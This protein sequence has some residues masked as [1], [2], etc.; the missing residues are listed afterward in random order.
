MVIAI[1]LSCQ[2]ILCCLVFCILYQADT[3]KKENGA[4]DCSNNNCL[5][6]PGA[7][8]AVNKSNTCINKAHYSEYRQKDSKYAFF[9]CVYFFW[10]QRTTKPA[11]AV[12]KL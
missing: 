9:H 10:Q 5:Y 2:C 11:H 1:N 6:A 3:R 7:G 4:N 8:T 12:A